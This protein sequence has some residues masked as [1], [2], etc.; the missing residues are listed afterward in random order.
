MPGRAGSAA[1]SSLPRGPCRFIHPRGGTHHRR[2]LGFAFSITSVGSPG[3][4]LSVSTW[5]LVCK[6]SLWGYLL[7]FFT[8]HL[9]Q[10]LSTVQLFKILQ[11]KPAAFVNQCDSGSNTFQMTPHPLAAPGDWELKPPVANMS[12]EA[13]NVQGK[14]WALVSELHQGGVAASAADVADVAK[15]SC[16]KKRK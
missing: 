7:D 5:R 10:D 12:T 6:F 9:H 16:K 15:S 3:S 1:G 14:S 11:E 13:T 2:A 8:V 4:I